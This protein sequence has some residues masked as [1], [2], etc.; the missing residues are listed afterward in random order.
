MIV[1][2]RRSVLYVPGANERA[3]AKARSLDADALIFD[4]EDA[5][6]PSAKPAARQAVAAALDAGGFGERERIVRINALT[7]PWGPEDLRAV[8]PLRFDALLLPKV[9]HPSHV[10]QAMAALEACGARDDL[11]IWCMIETPRGV[12]AADAVAGA[13]GRVAA[14]VLGTTDLTADLR[15]RPTPGREALLA[16]LGWCVLAARAHGLTI[17]DGVHLALDDEAGFAAACQQARD[18]GFDGKTLIHPRTIATANRV[19]APSTDEVAGARAVVAA[20]RQAEA[21]GRGV[22]VVG[23]RLVEALHLREAERVLTLAAALAAR[24]K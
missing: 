16:S 4:L 21:R 1:R 6:A 23:G 22:A 7:S 5:V 8:A 24:Q 19:F 3:L 2:P 14:L 18:L 10:E 12:L 11:P 20:Y 15:A 13:S 17:L 9:E